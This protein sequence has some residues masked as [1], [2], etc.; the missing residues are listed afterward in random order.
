[1][2]LPYQLHQRQRLQNQNKNNQTQ[3]LQSS[4]DILRDKPFWIWDKAEHLRLAKETNQN[5]CFNHIVKPPTKAGR[6]RPLW[7]YQKVIFDTLMLEDSSF[8]DK[9]LYLL[10]STGLGAS[11][12]FLRIMAWLCTKDDTYRNSQMVIVTGPNWDLSIKLMKRLKAI[13]EPK[14]GLTFQDKETVLNLNGCVIE[15]FPSNHLDSFRSLT[16]PAFILC[17][18]SDMFRTSEQEEVRHVTERY[19]GKS[20]PYIVL[21]STPGD[22]LGLMASIKKEPEETC[23]YRRLFMDWTYGINKIY[24]TEDIAKAR[25]SPSWEREYCNRFSGR[26]GNLLSLLKIDTAI[27]TGNKLESIKP[28]N[29]FSCGIDPAFGSS[30]FAIVLTEYIKEE[31]KIRVLSAEQY[32]NH[33]DPQAMIDRIF[34]IHRKYWNCWFFVDSSARGFITSLKIAFGENPNYEKVDSVS[35]SNNFVLP[36]NFSTDNKKMISHLAALFNDEYIGV[37]DK[38]DKLIVALKSAQVNEYQFLKDQSAY[39]DLTDAISLSLKCYNV[40]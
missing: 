23:I 19:V 32:E 4:L 21:V 18:E 17:D 37:A 9:H 8:K 28:A 6:E 7:D 31:N 22:P 16:N 29:L 30:A 38:H 24:S 34:D 1:M 26:V 36:V 13:F 11:E 25:M 39:N 27:D 20:D 10:K 15:S 12:L 14:L 33:P 2:A 40:N 35:P 5:C 3:P